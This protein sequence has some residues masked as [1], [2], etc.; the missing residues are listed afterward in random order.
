MPV[1]R[2]PQPGPHTTRGTRRGGLQLGSDDARYITG[3]G[4]VLEASRHQLD[5]RA[6]LLDDESAGLPVTVQ[7]PGGMVFGHSWRQRPICAGQSSCNR[8]TLPTMNRSDAPTPPVGETAAGAD[9]RQRRGARGR[10]PRHHSLGD[11]VASAGTAAVRRM[12]PRGTRPERRRGRRPTTRAVRCA[13]SC[14][15]HLRARAL[16]AGAFGGGAG[17]WL[18]TASPARSASR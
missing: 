3:S 16:P 6:P 5:R 8:V 10:R 2:I 18:D 7:I 11:D 4:L 12:D 1:V 9:L 13:P 14:R 17:R 15:G